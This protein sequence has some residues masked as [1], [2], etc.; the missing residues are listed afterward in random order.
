VDLDE[1]ED[2]RRDLEDESH[3]QDEDRDKRE[4]VR[5]PQLV[6]DDLLAEVDQELDRVRQQDEVAEQHARHE[7]ADHRQSHESNEAPLFREERR[8]D[9]R[10]DLVQDH[11]HREGE[12]GEQRD[13]EIGRE[14]LGRTEGDERRRRLVTGVGRDERAIHR[15]EEDPNE[16]GAEVERHASGDD[17]RDRADDQT[18]S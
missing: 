15:N 3:A 1:R 8:V 18:I 14:V 12:A 6:V 13:P 11:R 7:E 9:V 4:V 16:L 5:G 17:E 2:R 10:V